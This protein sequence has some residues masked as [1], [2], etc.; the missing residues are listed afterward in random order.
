MGCSSG[1]LAAAGGER[2]REATL[3][4]FRQT[5]NSGGGGDGLLLLD[6]AEYRIPRAA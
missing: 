5:A 4:A 3:A 2:V 6:G 1:I